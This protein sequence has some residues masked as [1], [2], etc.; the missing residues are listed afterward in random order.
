[1]PEAKL[2]PGKFGDTENPFW[3]YPTPTAKRAH[4]FP[5]MDTT[6]GCRSYHASVLAL[7]AEAGP[8]SQECQG[9]AKAAAK[10]AA[11]LSA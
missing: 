4:W 11:K 5:K 3:A 2:D 6:S 8:W 7:M 1:M 10:A 9:C